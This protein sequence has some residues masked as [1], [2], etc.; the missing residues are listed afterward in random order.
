MFGKFLTIIRGHPPVVAIAGV[1]GALSLGGLPVGST[2]CDDRGAKSL[3]DSCDRPGPPHQRCVF[4][5]SGRSGIARC[6]LRCLGICR[7]QRIL[8]VYTLRNFAVPRSPGSRVGSKGS[9]K[10]TRGIS[11]ACTGRWV[12]TLR[13]FR[14]CQGRFAGASRRARG[15]FPGVLRRAFG[16]K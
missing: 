12:R 3:C 5:L 1:G 2:V 6:V 8:H 16:R 15:L 4:P 14:A 10:R 11:R 9:R 7:P 13:N